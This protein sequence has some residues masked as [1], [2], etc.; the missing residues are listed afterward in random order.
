M[1]ARK[2]KSGDMNGGGEGGREARKALAE[3]PEAYAI[4]KNAAEAD[5]KRQAMAGVFDGGEETPSVI[6]PKPKNTGKIPA[7]P[8][9]FNRD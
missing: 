5:F 1:S 4:A 9:G 7:P 2:A 8:A 3:G 6:T